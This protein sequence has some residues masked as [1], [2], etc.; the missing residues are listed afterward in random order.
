MLTDGI[1]N[2]KHLRHFLGYKFDKK[3][4][5][6]FCQHRLN[7]MNVNHFIFL[8]V[9]NYSLKFSIITFSH[10]EFQLEL[11]Q[12]TKSTLRQNECQS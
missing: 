2:A 4:Y 10:L 1:E 9:F 5:N 11:R 3:N 8:W 6:F 7:S 12:Q